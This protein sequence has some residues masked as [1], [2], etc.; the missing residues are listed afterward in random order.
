MLLWAGALIQAPHRELA[1]QRGIEPLGVY[2]SY[3]FHGS[4]ANRSGL[5]AMLRIVEIN[6]EK[7]ETIDVFKKQIEKYKNNKFIQIKVLDLLDRESLI[8]VKQNKYYWPDRRI[9]RVNDE[10]RSSDSYIES[11]EQ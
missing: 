7:I 1:L 2:V 11:T 9:Y 8:S 6:G 3:V 5:H 10:W 4:P